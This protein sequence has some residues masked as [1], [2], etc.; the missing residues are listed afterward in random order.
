MLEE[1]EANKQERKIL[2]F[3]AVGKVRKFDM[4]MTNFSFIDFFE[5]G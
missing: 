5:K 2:L 4:K 1:N 3:Y